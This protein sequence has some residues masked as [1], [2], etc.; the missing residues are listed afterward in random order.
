MDNIICNVC[1]SNSLKQYLRNNYNHFIDYKLNIYF[2][3]KRYTRI[4]LSDELIHVIKWLR[5]IK[6]SSIVNNVSE[7]F[8]KNVYFNIKII[9]NWSRFE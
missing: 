9:L 1:V 8:F 4:I 3:K 7:N 2:I 5:S 6:V